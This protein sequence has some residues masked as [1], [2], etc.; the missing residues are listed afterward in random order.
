MLQNVTVHGLCCFYVLHNC[1]LRMVLVWQTYTLIRDPNGE[2]HVLEAIFQL[3]KKIKKTVFMQWLGW[4]ISTLHI[5]RQRKS[6]WEVWQWTS[7]LIVNLNHVSV[8]FAEL[9]LG[10]DNRVSNIMYNNGLH[11]SQ[12]LVL[13]KFRKYFVSPSILI[14]ICDKS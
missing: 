11:S 4:H 5:T 6:A 1:T 7:N 10:F 8:L 3:Y 12:W 13:L 14:I 2:P 9:I